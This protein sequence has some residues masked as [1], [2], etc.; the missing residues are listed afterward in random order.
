MEPTR[1]FR[2]RGLVADVPAGLRMVVRVL[3]T[4]RPG[5]RH[6]EGTPEGAG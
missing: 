2:A 1:I 5:A 3:D 4:A 6:P